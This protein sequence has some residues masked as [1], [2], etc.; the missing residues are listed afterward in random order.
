MCG[1]NT[2]IVTAVELGKDH[3]GQML[4]ALHAKTADTFTIGEVCADKAYLS[5]TNL[6]LIDG[7]GGVPLITRLASNAHGT[8]MPSMHAY[9]RRVTFAW[10][11]FF[12]AQ[13]TVSAG[14]LALASPGAWSVFI[15]LLNL[16]LLV[17]MF[18]GEHLYRITFH[19]E[20]PRAS[21]AMV[22]GSF[23]KDGTNPPGAQSR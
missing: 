1:V 14:L 13:L 6:E 16:P 4:P 12:L 8:L 17:A 9:T 11:V 23:V 15:N 7:A 3:D 2:H 5:K 19:P 22:I 21:L 10:C 20:F 18:V